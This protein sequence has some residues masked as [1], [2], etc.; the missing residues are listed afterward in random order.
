[1][2]KRQILIGKYFVM[3]NSSGWWVGEA[4]GP[5]GLKQRLCKQLLS[6]YILHLNEKK[7][8]R[9]HQK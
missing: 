3:K 8:G 7:G 9:S 6:V 4:E 1:M 5:P 2:G